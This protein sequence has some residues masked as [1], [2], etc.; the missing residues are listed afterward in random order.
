MLAHPVADR[1]VSRL[2][3]HDDETSLRFEDGPTLIRKVEGGSL[4]Y[5]HKLFPPFA[6]PISARY[7]SDYAAFLQRTNGATLYGNRLSL[8]GLVDGLSRSID[9]EHTL[10][11]S[12]TAY[13]REFVLRN[14]LPAAIEGGVGVGAVSGYAELFDLV[15]TPDE[16]LHIIGPG[17]RMKCFDGLLAGLD[18][19]FTVCES[20]LT[21]EMCVDSSR[22]ERELMGLLTP[23]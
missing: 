3:E 10:P 6:G 13:E 11:I 4:A 21:G 20:L 17:A 15:I 2:F 23:L 7:G 12:M 9:P 14:R 8:Y 22:L 18:V 1:L 16:R 5:L 19:L